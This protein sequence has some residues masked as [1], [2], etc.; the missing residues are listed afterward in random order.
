VPLYF[1]N[2]TTP[3]E[4]YKVLRLPEE[5]FFEAFIGIGVAVEVLVLLKTDYPTMRL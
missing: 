1:C 5:S 2:T 4:A 3:S